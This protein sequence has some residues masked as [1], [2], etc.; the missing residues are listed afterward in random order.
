MTKLSFIKRTSVYIAWSLPSC[1][2]AQALANVQVDAD[3]SDAKLRWTSNVVCF[4]SF[5]Q[6]NQ[7]RNG[8]VQE[9][10]NPQP[11]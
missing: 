5:I 6:I 2:L 11:V 4:I 7:C 8:Q 10:H 1:R 9:P 3:N